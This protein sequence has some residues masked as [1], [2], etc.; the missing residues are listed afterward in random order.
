MAG[1]I[2]LIMGLTQMRCG[3]CTLPVLYCRNASQLLVA[4]C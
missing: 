2:V 3:S 1:M 4:L